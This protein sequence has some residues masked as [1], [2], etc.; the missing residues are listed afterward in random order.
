MIPSVNL[1]LVR[2]FAPASLA[3]LS[4]CVAAGGGGSTPPPPPPPSLALFAGNLGGPGSC[5]GIGAAASF[6]QPRAVATDTAGN[7]YVADGNNN[8]VRK[9]TPTGAV[10][11]LAGTVG[12]LGSA[13]GTGAAASFGYPS[14]VATDSSGNVYVVDQGTALRKITSAGVVS[15]LAGTA[16][17]LGNADGAGAAA[18]FSWLTGVATDGAGNVYV[19]DYYDNSVRRISMIRK[20]TPAGVVTTFA[21]TPGVIGSADGTGA[22]ASFNLPAGLA[23]DSSGN[24]YVADSKNNTIRKITPAGAVST[25]A[26]TAGMSGSANGTG[27][28]ARFLRPSGVTTD[29]TGNVYV[30]DCGDNVSNG[31]IRKITPGGVVSTF[32]GTAGAVGSADGAGAAASFHVPSGV[33]TDSVGNIY[34]ADLGNSTI[35]KVT[36]GGVVSTL[37]GSP[38]VAGIADGPG[39]AAGFNRPRGVATDKAGNVYV[40]DTDNATIRRI[41][42][43]GVVITFAGTAGMYGSTDTAGGT[44]SFSSPYGLATDSAGNVYVAD[45]DNNTIRK[46]T[47]TGV[48]TTLAGSAGVAGSTDTT[49]GTPSFNQ[50]WG[51]ATDATGNVYVADSINYII[52]KI[53]PV[54]V[55]TTLAGTA[56]NYGSSNG[57]GAAASFSNLTGITTDSA[58]NVYVADSGNNTI[59]K[60]TP[61]GVVST[62]AGTAG[63][64]GSADGV[65]SAASFRWPTGVATDSAGNVYVADQDNN[66]IRKITPNGVVTTVAGVAGKLGFTPG[67]LPGVLGSPTGVA[68]H[69]STMYIT[70]NN[71]VAVVKNLP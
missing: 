36:P 24:V 37:A 59:R 64:A 35:R 17:V 22:A 4:A 39:V 40:A 50:P 34:V 53:T 2:L 27:Q 6:Y 33:A 71:G 66:T 62:F 55:V 20:V 3:L 28:L 25:L 43:A 68:I 70:F 10:S 46:I 67:V 14:G 47:P 51:L 1:L 31:T 7:V 15:T 9:V 8:T 58:G 26:G 5:D 57:T 41:T 12:V 32:A 48:V 30:A 63:V 19:S 61:A 45:Q 52:R 18:S 69:G 42:P 29:S 54:G 65:G 21:G 13:D 16:G 60:I 56:G 44:P 49:V 23:T 38:R 11:T